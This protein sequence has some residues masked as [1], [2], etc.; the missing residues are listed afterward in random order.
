MSYASSQ[1]EMVI[2]GPLRLQTAEPIEVKFGRI[3]DV[4]KGTRMQKSVYATL[5]AGCSGKTVRSHTFFVP[6]A[7]LQRRLF[8]V[9]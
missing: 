4:R 1:W 7:P 8:N 9:A 2:F 5:G 6:R 3:G